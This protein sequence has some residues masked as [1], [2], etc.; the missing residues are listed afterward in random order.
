MV[1]CSP[2]CRLDGRPS[3]YQPSP[4]PHL[5]PVVVGTMHEITVSVDLMR[6]GYFVYR[7]LSH[8]APHDL[9]AWAIGG[10]PI[11]VEV[12]SGAMYGK[13]LSHT[14]VKNHPP[15]RYDLLALVGHCGEIRYIPEFPEDR[16]N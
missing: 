4:Y 9:V 5:S 3:H 2:K 11:R 12:T 16:S 10:D 7:S 14:N 13:T 15:E 8:C 1:Y 6:R